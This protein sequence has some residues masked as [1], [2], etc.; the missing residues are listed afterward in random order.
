MYVKAS[1]RARQTTDSAMS[2]AHAVAGVCSLEQGL[3]KSA[4]KLGIHDAE[5]GTEDMM[6]CDIEHISTDID[7]NDDGCSMPP[8]VSLTADVRCFNNSKPGWAGDV[9]SRES[10]CS[11]STPTKLLL[12]K[13]IKILQSQ[14]WKLSRRVSALSAL[15]AAAVTNK[16]KQSGTSRQASSVASFETVAGSLNCIQSEFF[17]SQ[18][19]ATQC[20]QRGVRWT[21]KFKLFCLQLHYKS[22]AAYRFLIAKC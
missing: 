7:V 9:T 19:Q 11:K 16:T 15:T 12:R 8:G 10:V 2:A 13:R 18:L 22:P 4:E 1:T 5:R 20:K 21:V 3:G 6:Y 14:R 17:R